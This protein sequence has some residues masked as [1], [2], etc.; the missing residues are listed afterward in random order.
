MVFQSVL[1]R[2]KGFFP[3]SR[4]LFIFNGLLLCLLIWLT[5]IMAVRIFENE[6]LSVPDQELKYL[7]Q[8]KHTFDKP[9]KLSEFQPIIK[10][11]VFDAEVMPEK[12]VDL[13]EPEKPVSGIKLKKILSDLELLGIGYSQGSFIYSIIN[14]KKLKKEDI[15]TIGDD[16]FDTGAI[17]KRIFTTTG[18]QRVYFRLGN[19]EGVLKYEENVTQKPE[20]TQRRTTRTTNR[21]STREATTK[22]NSTQYT[23]DGKNYYMSSA[24][25]DSHI[26][27][28]GKLM[29]QAKAVP[30]FRNGKH[31]GFQFK[32]IDKGSLYEK[33]GIRNNDIIQAVNGEALNTMEKAMSLLK[34][35][36]TEREFTIKILRN[37]KSIVL[38]Y[39]ID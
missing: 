28:F 31:E 19:E 14:N 1:L 22:S 5:G 23:T 8:N 26:S 33:L 24:E 2:I 13:V 21:P 15:F 27:D 4:F 29:N 37:N 11:N 35:V 9:I 10:M 3:L 25:V 30:F 32:A 17:I 12:I 38:N 36:R 7:R 34:T 6:I 16:V 18:K 39:Y 20:K